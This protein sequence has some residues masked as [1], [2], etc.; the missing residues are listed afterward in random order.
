MQILKAF[1]YIFFLG[2][3]LACFWYFTV[4][5]LENAVTGT[6]EKV[7]TWIDYHS[8]DSEPGSVQYLRSI[9]TIFNIVCSVG[10]GDMFP[11]TDIERIFFTAMITLGDLL[12]AL[13]FGLITQITLQ[14]SL[15]NETKQFKDKMY[16]IQEFMNS[17]NLDQAQQRRVEQYFAY[18]YQ[19]KYNSN[20]LVYYDLIGYLPYQLR[21]EVIYQSSKGLLT[22]MFSKYRSENLIRKLA[23][24]LESVIFLPGDY[25]VYKEDIGNEMYF[26]A[27]GSVYVLADDK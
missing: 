15:T 6:Q 9:Y 4:S 13:A 2:H 10:Y 25:I 23:C 5:N 17:F 1:F 16:Q 21:E 12:F 11:M 3:F 26:I 18:E 22:S 14:I 20:L 7:E 8:L 19:Q 24:V 27:E